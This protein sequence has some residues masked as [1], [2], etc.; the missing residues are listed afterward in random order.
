MGPAA[1]SPWDEVWADPSPTAASTTAY[2]QQYAYDLLGNIR[3][4][5]HVGARAY[6]RGFDYGVTHNRLAAL[7]T[8][9]GAVTYTYDLAG[10][11][12][13]ENSSRYLRWDAFGRLRLKP[14]VHA[15]T[16]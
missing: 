10:N 5:T 6:T 14:G 9:S 1:V 3:Q 8:G 2:T 13:R 12:L 4:L 7:V 11:V 15:Y 16:S